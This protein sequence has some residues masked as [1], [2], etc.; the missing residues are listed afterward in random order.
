MGDQGA[1]SSLYNKLAMCDWSIAE[2]TEEE[3]KKNDLRERALSQARKAFQVANELERESDRA[4]SGLTVMQY[5]RTLERFELVDEVGQ[6]L[7]DQQLWGTVLHNG[8]K[9]GIKQECEKLQDHG[10][11]S[12]LDGLVAK[13]TVK[14]QVQ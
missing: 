10:D 14:P 2:S 3:S 6:N 11:W 4:F 13:V 8:V 12:W 1:L 9:S 7:D 5:A